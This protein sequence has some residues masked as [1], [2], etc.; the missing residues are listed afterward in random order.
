MIFETIFRNLA[1]RAIPIARVVVVSL[2][3]L[4]GSV[5]LLLFRLI[6]KRLFFVVSTGEGVEEHG[7]ARP[8]LAALIAFVFQEGI[9]IVLFGHS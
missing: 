4:L 5:F 8:T 9:V 7:M 6:G 1:L 3:A 2:K